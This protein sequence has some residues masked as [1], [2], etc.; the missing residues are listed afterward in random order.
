MVNAINL[1]DGLDGLAARVVLFSALVLLVLAV[2][3]GTVCGGD[4]VCRPG[5]IDFGIPPVQFQ[6]GVYFHGRW[7]QLFSGVYAGGV[8]HHGFHEGLDHGGPPDSHRCHGGATDRR[9]HRA[10]P[11]LCTGAADVINRDR[12]LFS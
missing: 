12:N 3:G 6:P 8:E 9:H 1:I 10:D 11:P 5:G 7:Q 4:G 2:S